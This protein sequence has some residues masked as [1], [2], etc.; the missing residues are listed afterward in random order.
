MESTLERRAF[1][2]TIGPLTPLDSHTRKYTAVI[3]C[4]GIGSPRHYLSTGQFLDA[5]DA[6]GNL[7]NKAELGFLRSFDNR[8]EITN[9]SSLT[10]R[11]YVSFRR[12]VEIKG[13]QR[14]VKEYRV[15][16]AYWA[17]D[18][19]VNLT[20]Y[21]ALY[22]ITSILK[23][24]FLSAFSNWRSYPSSKKRAL[25]EAPIDEN[26]RRQLEKLYNEFGSPTARDAYPKGSFHDFITFSCSQNSSLPSEKIKELS[27]IWRR[28][29]FYDV[30]SVLSRV[31]FFGFP[32]ASVAALIF[33]S[34]LLIGIYLAG[35]YLPLSQPFFPVVLIFSAT[36]TITFLALPWYYVRRLVSDVISW[37]TINESHQNFLVRERRVCNA[38]RL[39]HD[40]LQDD[41]CD[42]CVLIG[43]SLGSSIILEAF[44]RENRLCRAQNID[45]AEKTRLTDGVKKV[46]HIFAVGSP[47]ESI[48]RFFQNDSARSHRYHRIKHT[49][50]NRLD[51]P[52]WDQSSSPRL[53]NFWSRYDPVSSPI[54]SLEASPNTKWRGVENIEVAPLGAPGP[55]RAHSGYFNDKGVMRVIYQAVASGKLSE[56]RIR[57]SLY[58]GKVSKKLKAVSVAVLSLVA[59]IYMLSVIGVLAVGWL[60]AAAALFIGI[61]CVMYMA[62]RCELDKHRQQHSQPIDSSY[63]PLNTGP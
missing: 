29:V 10:I 34:V 60:I 3:F 12:I 55:L 59:A 5:L 46:S 44:S 36:T 58:Q 56:Q 23:R 26:K 11:N 16:E 45:S 57:S 30:F 7:E 48:S 13:R 43:H 2:L 53:I 31:F 24:L 4:H 47:I 49:D 33:L 50:P 54:M 40:V 17:G 21:S 61:C 19:H 20:L 22:W 62:V 15:Y 52:A 39:I 6:Q 51:A 28:G 35:K 1:L 18:S 8:I 38:Q 25:R 37:T 9:R 63:G 41:G 14:P 42:R 27:I 32:L